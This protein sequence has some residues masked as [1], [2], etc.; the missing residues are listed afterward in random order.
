MNFLA[1]IPTVRQH[2]HWSAVKTLQSLKTDLLTAVK[3]CFPYTRDL[4]CYF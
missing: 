4:P 3:Q 2:F 1:K